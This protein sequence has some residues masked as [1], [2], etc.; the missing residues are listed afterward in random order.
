M[1]LLGSFCRG[2]GTEPFGA[3]WGP[4]LLRSSLQ[5]PRIVLGVVFGACGDQAGHHKHANSNN[6][7]MFLFSLGMKIVLGLR[8]K[9]GSRNTSQASYLHPKQRCGEA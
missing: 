3:A 9:K 2:L 4:V 1:F 8:A 5:P 6:K 7:F